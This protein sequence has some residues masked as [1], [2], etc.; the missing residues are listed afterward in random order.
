MDKPRTSTKKKRGP[1]YIAGGVVLAA[2]ITLGLSRLKPAP[3]S[4]ERAAI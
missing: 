2:L 4:V 3:P 1:I